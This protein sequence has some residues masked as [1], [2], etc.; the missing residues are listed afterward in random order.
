MSADRKDTVL[1]TWDESV[2]AVYVY[3]LPHDQWPSLPHQEDVHGDASLILDLDRSES[4]LGI[5]MLAPPQGKDGTPLSAHHW[6][7][8]TRAWERCHLAEL[9]YPPGS[10]INLSGS[11]LMDAGGKVYG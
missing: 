7:L 9:N 11:F 3:L 1:V 4:P 5:E 8:A 6:V 10:H 2:G